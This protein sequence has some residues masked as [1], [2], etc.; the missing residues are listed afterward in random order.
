MTISSD[1]YL[2]THRLLLAGKRGLAW[3]LA[4]LDA[5]PE[6]SGHGEE[7]SAS[8][9]A[10]GVGFSGQRLYGVAGYVQSPCADA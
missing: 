7:R 9:K 6:N 8:L 10:L 3:H 5:S 1:N 4:R 2:D